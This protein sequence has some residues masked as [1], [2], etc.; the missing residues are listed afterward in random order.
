M[1][2]LVLWCGHAPL[3]KLSRLDLW[4]LRPSIWTSK[5][6][7]VMSYLKPAL[8]RPH[9]TDLYSMYVPELRTWQRPP[10]IASLS[11]LLL[12]LALD[13]VSGL[14]LCRSGPTATN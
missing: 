3:D 6:L 14:K 5:N 13:L 4:M 11:V 1:H 2:V 10:T 12:G 9:L 8:G 7:K